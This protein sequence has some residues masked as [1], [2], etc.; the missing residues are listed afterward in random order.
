MIGMNE[1][2]AA[3]SA[4]GIW[5]LGFSANEKTFSGSQGQGPLTQNWVKAT[6]PCDPKLS[7]STDQPS[8]RCLTT[9]AMADGNNR[10]GTEQPSRLFNTAD[11]SQG[12]G[13]LTQNW[14]K[15]TCPCDP[16][17]PPQKKKFPSELPLPAKAED[18]LPMGTWFVEYLVEGI[19]KEGRLSYTI[20]NFFN[21]HSRR[22]RM[23]LDLAL[24]ILFRPMTIG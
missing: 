11:G 4:K 5:P 2:E 16:C 23:Q 15:A 20:F 1:V 17:R 24:I 13:P 22:I 21:F 8:R 10:D 19:L 18:G 14:G 12:Q 6:C 7:N 3:L 9:I